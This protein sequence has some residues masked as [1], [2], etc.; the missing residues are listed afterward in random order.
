MSKLVKTLKAVALDIDGVF[1][2]GGNLLPGAVKALNILKEYRIAHI[3]VT[4]G[5]GTTELSKSQ[6]LSEKFGIH[7]RPDQILLCHTPLQKLA[8]QFGADRVL[9][10]GHHRCLD[11]A[12]DYGN[13]FKTP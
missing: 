13:N 8:C 7:I 1:L 5:G 9:I 12:E 3:F 10:L 4:N 2:R 11:V 6:S